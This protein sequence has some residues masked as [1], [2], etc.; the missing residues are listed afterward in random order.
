M[1]IF[2][3]AEKFVSLSSFVRK[4]LV[5]QGKWFCHFCI[6]YNTWYLHADLQERSHQ[7]VRRN[8]KSKNG[9]VLTFL[10]L[11]YLFSSPGRLPLYWFFEEIMD[12]YR[13]LFW[14]GGGRRFPGN[15]QT[16]AE[17][18]SHDYRMCPSAERDWGHGACLFQGGLNRV[19]NTVNQSTLSSQARENW[20]AL[21]KSTLVWLWMVERLI[22][23]P[24]LFFIYFCHVSKVPRV[25][26]RK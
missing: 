24:G 5:D 22:R 17:T 23:A 6:A 10:W 4:A 7:D 11:I 21:H 13:W 2:R 16:V 26:S 25:T 20:R 8:G 9:S 18:A 1:S 3:S 12:F 19:N 15:L 14:T